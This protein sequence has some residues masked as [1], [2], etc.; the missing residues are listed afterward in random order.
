MATR[1]RPDRQRR[2][3]RHSSPNAEQQTNGA[4][5]RRLSAALASPAAVAIFLLLAGWLRYSLIEFESTDYI[6][7]V[8]RW[9]D[10]IVRYGGAAALKKGVSNYT[11]AYEYLL[12]LAV[13]SGLPKIV[14][15]KLVSIIFEFV[16]ALC[17]YKLVRLKYPD[18][19]WPVL[20]GLLALFAPTMVLNGSYWGQCDS[21][22]TTALLAC[23]YF[24][25][26][27]REALAFF[28][29]GLAFAIK[30][31]A[32][33]FM[34]LLV[35]LCVTR[36]VSWKSLLIIPLVYLMVIAPAWLLG[37]PLDELLLIYAS[38]TGVGKSL[39]LNAPNL[40][41]W[42]PNTYYDIVYPL[43]IA[44][45]MALVGGVFVVVYTHRKHI[46]PEMLVLL[47]T[48][49]VL[50]VPWFLPDM[51]DRYFF[52]ADV[53]SIVFA[54]YFPRYFYVPVVV[55]AASVLTYYQFLNGDQALR[56][57]R[58]FPRV[59]MELFAFSFEAGAIGLLAVIVLLSRHLLVTLFSRG[60]RLA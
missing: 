21:I 48:L 17:V 58:A 46:T 35:L 29:F 47:A 28:A 6:Y 16:C 40:Y 2:T 60:K 31:Q 11:P 9:Y 24:L 25:L 56:G 4:L 32:I 59:D 52:A 33:F 45:T 22:H 41:L 30:P 57:T 12:V 7:H 18:Q 3:D 19:P 1:H 37:R 8:S 15:L 55:N 53:L 10:D 36:T 49:F 23:L 51:H 20:A 39:T 26:R 13:F 50:I 54:F 44:W 5:T 27:K 14:A 42:I 38:Q 43:G 34:P